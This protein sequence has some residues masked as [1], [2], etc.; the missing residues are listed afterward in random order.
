VQRLELVILAHR[1]EEVKSWRGGSFVFTGGT[2]CLSFFNKS[3]T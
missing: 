2:S 3:Y 1:F